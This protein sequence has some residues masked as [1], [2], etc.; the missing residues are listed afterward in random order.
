MGLTLLRSATSL[1]ADD[2]SLA[3]MA[4]NADLIAIVRVEETLYQ[5]TR[6]FPSKGKAFLKV[7]IPYRGA[8]RDHLIEVEE[9]GLE[10]T[11][12]YYPKVDPF[13]FEG[14]RFLVFLRK[15]P[16]KPSYR[17][18]GPGCRL[19]I[20]VT[21]DSGYA[22]LQPIAGLKVPEDQVLDIDY[23]DPAAFLEAGELSFAEVRR[24]Q[25]EGT[26]RW[27]ENEDP[28]A[29]DREFLVY[30]RGVPISALRALMFPED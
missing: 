10:D 16:D 2:Q 20:L 1:L 18:R 24:L 17:G 11:A 4:A 14:Q 30:T 26:A 12:C 5:K 29:P 28:L 3:Q 21:A 8:E 15:S 25:A 9:E 13:A 6:D 19:P 27:H 22:L 23:S 7:L